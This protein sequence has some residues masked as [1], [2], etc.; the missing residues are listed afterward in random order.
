MAAE[1]Q[2][3]AAIVLCPGQGAQHVQMGQAWATQSRAAAAVF[4]QADDVLGMDLTKLCFEGPIE[5]LNRTDIAQAAIYTTSVACYAALQE[6]GLIGP[7]SAT[8]GLSL[9]E[10]TA[11]HLAGALDFASGL[12][13]VRLRGE[14]M[15]EA[16]EAS[17]GSMLAL[18][19]ADEEHAT[20]L[21]QQAADDDAGEVLVTANFNCPG[22]VVV[23]GSKAACQRAMG[24]AEQMRLRATALAV[25]GAYHS[26]LM[27]PAA[28]RLAEALDRVEWQRPTVPVL[29]NVTAKPH[30]GS[31]CA[32]ICR[33][34]LEQMTR[35]VRWSESMSWALAN[36][37]GQFIELG[38]GKVLSGLMRRIDRGTKVCN[39]A[40]P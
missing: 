35:P 30:D 18:I 16:A 6:E 17:D 37:E 21:C 25:I 32:S 14:A 8:A 10:F 40:A 33:L 20:E 13:L 15:Q 12:K 36:L 22:Q 19:G 28:K 9:G 39:R 4:E 7:L 27:A 23:S 38:P 5:Q 26:P 3:G 24:I 2:G 34:L 29:S 11:L 31:D 1:N